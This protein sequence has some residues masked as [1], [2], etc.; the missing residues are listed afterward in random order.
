MTNRHRSRK[1][2]WNIGATVKV[3]FLTFTVAGKQPTPGDYRPDIWL[4]TSAKGERY[5]FQPHLGLTKGWA[6]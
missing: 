3:G 4:L 2:E 5:S 6:Q 1:Q